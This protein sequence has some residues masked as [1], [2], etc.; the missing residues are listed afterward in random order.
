MKEVTVVPTHMSARQIS[1]L[2]NIP[3]QRIYHANKIGK[4][5][6]SNPGQYC[7][8]I[9]DI[10]KWRGVKITFSSSSETDR[11]ERGRSA[12]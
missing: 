3:L 11:E 7:Y 9:A 4:L 6:R 2:L 12:S 5:P 10:E 1:E 8:A